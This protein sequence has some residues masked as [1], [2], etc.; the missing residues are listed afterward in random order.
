MRNPL[1]R[2]DRTIIR[3]AVGMLRP[4]ADIMP[5]YPSESSSLPSGRVTDD[6]ELRM[7]GIIGI[8]PLGQFRFK[9]QD[10]Y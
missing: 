3:T 1:T 10:G 7:V 9:R 8:T 4:S 2:H 6:G 5:S